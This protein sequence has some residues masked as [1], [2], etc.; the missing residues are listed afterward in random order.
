M[1]DWLGFGLCALFLVFEIGIF[2]LKII[3]FLGHSERAK[4]HHVSIFF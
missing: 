4:S 1:A 2:P 3:A